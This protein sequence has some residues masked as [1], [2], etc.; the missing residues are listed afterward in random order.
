MKNK[1]NTASLEFHPS[2][3]GSF[4]TAIGTYIGIPV[5]CLGFTSGLAFAAAGATQGT[6]G[7]TWRINIKVQECARLLGSGTE[8]S[9]ITNGALSGTWKLSELA[10]DCGTN[11]T[12][13]KDQVAELISDGNRKQFIR[14]HATLTGTATSAPKLFGGFILQSRST[15]YVQA[16]SSVGTNNKEVT[17]SV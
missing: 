12:L 5:D 11:S 6:A 3:I 13:Y 17:L 7:V 16:A 15:N 4:S 8:W 10:A 9:D 14:M 1:L 2:L